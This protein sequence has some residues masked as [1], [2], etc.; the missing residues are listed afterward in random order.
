MAIEPHFRGDGDNPSFRKWLSNLKQVGSNILV[1]G[2]VPT[3]VSARVSRYLFGRELRRFRIL[4]LTDQTITNADARLPDEASFEDPET[5]TIDQRRGERSVPAT[6]RDFTSGLDSLQTDDAQQ[7]CNEIQT[8]IS[9]Y[10]E[11]VDGLDPAEL[12]VGIDSLYPL[13]EQDSDTVG[14]VLRTL[15]ATVRGVHGMGHYHLRISPDDEIVDEL[16]PL[17]DARVE[18]RKRPRQNTEQRWYA[19]ELDAKTPWMEL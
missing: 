14:R 7:L 19:P 10:D 1:T 18:L 17:F 4:A 13:L 15:G 9:F 5:W 3:E 8:A 6:A 16:M 12:R 11:K 2:E